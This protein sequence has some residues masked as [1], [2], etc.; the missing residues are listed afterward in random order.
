M[1]TREVEKNLNSS[2]ESKIERKLMIK[3]SRRR[4]NRRIP[5]LVTCPINNTAIPVCEY[6]D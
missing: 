3:I 4:C 2:N 6:E 5:D 1:L